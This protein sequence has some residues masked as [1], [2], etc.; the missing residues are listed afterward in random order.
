MSWIVSPKNICQSPNSQNLQIWTY[1]GIRSLQMQSKVDELHK[2]RVGPNLMTGVLIRRGDSGHRHTGERP[3]GTGCRDSSR[4]SLN[5]GMP[6]IA[7][8]HQKQRRNLPLEPFRESMD[9][10]TSWFWTS[11]LQNCEKINILLSWDTW[12]VILCYCSP[13]WLIQ[14]S[15]AQG[16]E[17]ILY[18]YYKHSW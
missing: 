18:V 8:N 14:S 12:F 16:A 10:P 15:T 1:L 4:V 9:L 7:G 11:N 3:C 6:K 2:T 17:Q 5:Q 13:K